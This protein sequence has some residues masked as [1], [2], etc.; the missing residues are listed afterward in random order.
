MRLNPTT[1]GYTN[2][3]CGRLQASVS[4]FEELLSCGYVINDMYTPRGIQRVSGGVYSLM[5]SLQ[6]TAVFLLL[7]YKEGK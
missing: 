1:P 4:A 5:H 7:P 3:P 6:C 2:A